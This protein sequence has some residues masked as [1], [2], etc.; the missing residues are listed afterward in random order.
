MEYD[1]PDLATERAHS[2]RVYD[3]ML[4]GKDNYAADRAAAEAILRL[5]P[6]VRIAAV[7]NRSFMH[8][9]VRFVAEQG[10][11]QFLDIGTGIPTEPNLHQV[12][13][14]VNPTC[15]VVYVDKDPLVLAHAAAF[16]R[17]DP[18]GRTAYVQADLREPAAILSSPDLRDVL[19]TDRPIGLSMIALLHF[20]TDD[21]EARAII[22]SLTGALAPGSFLVLTH[23]TDEFDR[24]RMQALAEVFS[25]TGFDY[26]FRGLADLTAMVDG[27]DVVE[28][29][30]V[31]LHTWRPD[32]PRGEAAAR[33]LDR[34]DVAGYGVVARK[35]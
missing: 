13:Q 33:A 8:R 21:D 32:G 10:V 20:V 3:Y 12:V 1:E 28:P 27:L 31:P 15:R 6:A 16:M 17:S 19:D 22:A 9:A 25:G 26:R 5:W 35:S 18:R 24:E 7:A 34:R 14:S 2:A 30:I 23:G 29:G 11:T 4:G